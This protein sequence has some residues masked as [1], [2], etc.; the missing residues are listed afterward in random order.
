MRNMFAT[1]L[2]AL[3]LSGCTVPAWSPPP[4]PELI[5]IEQTEVI[6][7]N[8]VFIPIPDSQCAW[9]AVADVID[10]YFK[11]EKE[12]PM[13][14]IGGTPG[15]GHIDE[16]VIETYYQVS[17]TLLESWRRDTAGEYER[18]ENTLQTMRRRAVVRVRP[19]EG[20]HWV[21]VAVF[22][23]LEDLRTPENASAGSATFRYDSSFTRVVN[24]TAGDQAPECWIPKGRDPVLEQRIIGHL[25]F[26]CNELGYSMQTKGAGFGVQGSGFG[27]QG[28]GF[29]VQGSGL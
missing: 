16:G 15:E 29:G 10:D 19:S 9:E 1:L 8:P 17:P 25:I 23:E 28:S 11:I 4:P 5:P 12:T 7:P 6:Y 21:D 26:N 18:V 2:M 14:Q 22:K 20:G 3:G 27:V 24:P 13:R